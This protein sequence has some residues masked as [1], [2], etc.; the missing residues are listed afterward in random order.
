ME[1]LKRPK[2]LV[3]PAG[4]RKL[5]SVRKDRPDST[6]QDCPK[7]RPGAEK[8]ERS[9]Y[10]KQTIRADGDGVLKKCSVERHRRPIL[11]FTERDLIG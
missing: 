7:V 8:K 4:V 2:R 11:G 10:P 5:E 6:H 1:P 9:Y 3:G